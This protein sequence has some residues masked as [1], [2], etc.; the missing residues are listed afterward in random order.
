MLTAYQCE[1]VAY[2][3]DGAI[4]CPSCAVKRYTTVGVE[5]IDAGLGIADVSPLCRYTLDEHNG[6]NASQ[7]ATETCD[8]QTNPELWQKVY[9]EYPSE[10]CDDCG[11]A[12]S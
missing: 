7:Y 12:M 1:T 10:H 5:R 8:Y 3:T 6:S 11:G 2:V 4:I 9:D